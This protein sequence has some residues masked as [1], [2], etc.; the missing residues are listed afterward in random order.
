MSEA[1]AYLLA[2]LQR[3]ADGGDVTAAELDA[4]I[5]EPLSLGRLER[6]AW[7]ELSH[8]TDDADIRLKDP[9]YAA[10]KRKRMQ[11]C[12]AALSGYLPEEIER[13]EHRASHV[14]VWGC[15][16]GMLLAAGAAYL[17][18]S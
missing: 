6:D 14:P 9:H 4:A 16:A 5:A 15:F 10:Y 3:V 17:L 8:W 11:D 2:T 12:I 13:G 18:L 1:R 7:E